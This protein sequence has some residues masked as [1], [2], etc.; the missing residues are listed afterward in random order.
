MPSSHDPLSLAFRLAG[1][2]ALCVA[3]ATVQA[4][5][6]PP[7]ARTGAATPVRPSVAPPSVPAAPAAPAVPSV[8]PAAP[9][10]VQRPALPPT[11]AASATASAPAA[12][13][14]PEPTAWTLG[15]EVWDRPRSADVIRLLP[16]VRAA[17][18]ALAGTPRAS[19]VIRHGRGQNEGLRAEELRH[20]LVALAIE[21]ERIAI[22]PA[23]AASIEG[24][25]RGAMVLEL[26]R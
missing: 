5:P 15:D 4:Q 16:A 24:L 20:W 10:A 2:L 9:A 1:L 14:V 18:A 25:P 8:A 7:P 6:A 23:A 17:V 22:T 3:A 21:P 11:Q 19:L 12:V 13:P 26:A